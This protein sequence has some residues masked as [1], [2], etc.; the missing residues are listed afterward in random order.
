M[1]AKQGRAEYFKERRKVFKQFNVSLKKEKIEEAIKQTDESI[2]KIKVRR[3]KLLNEYLNGTIPQ[4]IYEENERLLKTTLL[5]KKN[6]LKYL[7]KQL[8]EKDNISNRISEFRKNIMNN[9]ILEEF[10]R[11]VFE[12]IV[13]KAI[14]GGFDENGNKDPY[15]ITLY[16]KQEYRMK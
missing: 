13:E 10:D 2:Q 4:D 6:E 3:N 9:P 14:V 5:N 11:V 15:K 12:S 8:D 7:K 1:V 16:I